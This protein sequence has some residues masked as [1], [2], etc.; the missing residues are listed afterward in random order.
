MTG[1][2]RAARPVTLRS[3]PCRLHVLPRWT[4]TGGEAPS[5]WQETLVEWTSTKASAL[6]QVEIQ[7]GTPVGANDTD[8]VT[9]KKVANVE[10]KN[11]YRSTP[12]EGGQG[13][14]WIGEPSDSDPAVVSGLITIEDE[15]RVIVVD[16]PNG[17]EHNMVVGTKPYIEWTRTGPVQPARVAIKLTRTGRLADEVRIRDTVTVENTAEFAWI[18]IEPPADHCVIWIDVTDGT[19]SNWPANVKVECHGARS[20]RTPVR[21]LWPEG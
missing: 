20:A 1:P 12:T 6:P 19:P 15:P 8:W 21:C 2:A 11:T 9:I 5:A 16:V 18:L 10:R 17:T 3:E 14:I 4:G 7:C 13:R